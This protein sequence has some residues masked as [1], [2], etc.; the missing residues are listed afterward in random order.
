MRLRNISATGA[1]IDCPGRVPVDSEVVLDLDQA[2]SL[3]AS[4]SWTVGDHI[5]LRFDQPFDLRR[6]SKSKPDVTPAK[7]LR[8]SY[9]EEDVDPES[10]WD[11]SWRRMSVDDLR[12]ELEGF[13][14][15]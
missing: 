4:V 9:L 14:K 11:D 15:R 8:P 7:W 13:L 1:L 5:G 6:L 10:L 12:T 3:L 2:G